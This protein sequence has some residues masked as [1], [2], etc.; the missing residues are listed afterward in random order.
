MRSERYFIVLIHI[1]S[2]GM[3]L[4]IAEFVK[5]NYFETS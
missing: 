5:L 3:A 4:Q 1:H 2:N